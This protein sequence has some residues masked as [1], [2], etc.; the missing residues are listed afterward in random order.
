ML[1]RTDTAIRPPAG[2]PARLSSAR[3]WAWL[4]TLA[5]GL[6]L[7]EIVRWGYQ[8]THNPN[9][10]PS[11]LLLGAVVV[12]ASF[13]TFVFGLGG[14]FEVDGLTLVLVA[15]V[16]GVV[17]VVTSGLLE[18]DTLRGLGTLPMVAVAG[19]EEAAKLMAPA[20]VLM[21][22]RRRRPANGLIV[23]VACGAGFAVM[24]T[25]G[26]SAVALLRSHENVATVDTLLLQRGMFSPAT[27]MAWTG[28]TAATLWYATERGWDR[29][30]VGTLIA[31]F[32]LA[33][34]LHAGWDSTASMSGYVIL[35]VVSLAALTMATHKV[36]HGAGELATSAR[37][38]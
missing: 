34:V 8:S 32:G 21:T 3:R 26:Y 15:F 1:T 4:V 29:R 2:P 9:L 17:G 11:L 30:G 6:V 35:A 7:F 12:P 18:F 13:A 25:L 27:H 19:I 23:G 36:I 20:V 24:E 33:V 14:R 31:V 10:V 22:T 38:R 5:A 16:G 37:A 28:L